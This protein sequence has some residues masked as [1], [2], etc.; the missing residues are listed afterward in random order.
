MKTEELAKG[1]KRVYITPQLIVH[2]TVEE[3]TALQNKT[4]GASD[5]GACRYLGGVG[6]FLVRGGREIVVDPAPG[7]EAR[8]LRLSIL[9]PA[10]GLLLH[11]RGRF[12]LHAS[13]VASGGGVLAFAGGS[14][15]G[16]STL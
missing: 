14:G 13:A 5:D 6:A 4:Y 12:V 8:V 15:W 1:E 3:I 16:K 9:G 2:G 7:V 11:Q 10:F